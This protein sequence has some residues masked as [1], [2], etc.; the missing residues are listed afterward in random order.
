MNF[1]RHTMRSIRVFTTLAGFGLACSVVMGEAIRFSKPAVPLAAPP[2]AE[3]DL[4]E[5]RERGLD[6]SNPNFNAPAIAPV[7]PL[8]PLMRSEP[9]DLERERTHPLLRTPAMFTDPDEEKARKEALIEARDHPFSSA[10]EKLRPGP[11]SMPDLAS[12]FRPDSARSL[13]PVTDL[14]WRPSQTAGG[15]KD[16]RRG[17][18]GVQSF[19][20]RDDEGFSAQGMRARTSFEFNGNRAQEKLTPS[21]LQR[22]TDFEQLLN[23]NAGPAGQGLNSL[24]PVANAAEGKSSTLAVPPAGGGRYD[25]RNA[26]PTAVFN[27]RQDHLRGPVIEDVNKRYNAAPASGSGAPGSGNQTSPARPP[28]SREFPARKF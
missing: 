26:D 22:K 23:P 17:T 15:S 10:H 27:R 12:P 6:F 9:R 13:S 28:V 3:S 7:R 18:S 11:A 21:Q 1:R 5:V 2:K 8:P 25:P 4:P 14:D 19:A 20:S 16:T 24:L